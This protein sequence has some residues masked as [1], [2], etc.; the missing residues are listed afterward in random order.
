MSRFQMHLKYR[1]SSFHIF[2][3]EKVKQNKLYY[4]Y[5][6]YNDYFSYYH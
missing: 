4:G 3:N 5:L 2:F 1:I 6:Y